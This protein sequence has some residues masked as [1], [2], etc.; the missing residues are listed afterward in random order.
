MENQ[1][2]TAKTRNKRQTKNGRLLLSNE[3]LYNAVLNQRSFNL[4]LLFNA[5][6]RINSCDLAALKLI[7]TILLLQYIRSNAQLNRKRVVCRLNT[8]FSKENMRT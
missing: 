4:G 6:R 7:N 1:T 2:T 5:D 8:L 3:D